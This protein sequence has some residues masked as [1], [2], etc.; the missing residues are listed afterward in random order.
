[1][2]NMLRGTMLKKT[3]AA[4]VA[5]AMSL[6]ELDRASHCPENVDEDSW[7][8]LCELRRRKIASEETIQALDADLY[9]TDQAVYERQVMANECATAL[10]DAV[11]YLET[12]RKDRNYKLNNT[13]VTLAITQGQLELQPQRLTTSLPGATLITESIITKLN[14]DIQVLTLIYS[15]DVGFVFTFYV[16]SISVWENQSYLQ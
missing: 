6:E 14:Q 12:W 8:H 13:E 10:V 7:K 16:V 1:M 15:I 2:S 4:T 5:M 9:E 3:P 11:S